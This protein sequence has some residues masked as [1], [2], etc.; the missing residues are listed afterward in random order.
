MQIQSIAETGRETGVRWPEVRQLHPSLRQP[1]WCQRLAGHHRQADAKAQV[2]AG[3]GHGGLPRARAAGVARVV[4]RRNGL[5]HQYYSDRDGK[6]MLV[7]TN[8]I[9]DLKHAVISA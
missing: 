5:C 9:P 2:G 1:P 8:K 6:L 3:A 4:N 7:T